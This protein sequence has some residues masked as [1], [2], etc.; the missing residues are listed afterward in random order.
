MGSMT[1]TDAMSPAAEAW[2]MLDKLARARRARVV[3]VAAELDLSPAQATALWRLCPGDPLPMRDLAQALD[4]DNSSVTAIADRL[5]QQGLIRRR[6]AAHDRRLRMLE[7][8]PRGAR[9]RSK[10]IGSLEAPPVALE[11]MTVADQRLLCEL[12]RRALGS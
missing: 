8:T 4:C 11:A 7:V 12:L 10:L 2:R 5:E 9:L 3:A 6:A 1:T